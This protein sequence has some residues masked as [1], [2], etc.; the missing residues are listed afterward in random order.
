ME[1][2]AANTPADSSAEEPDITP[3]AAAAPGTNLTPGAA[4][5]IDQMRAAVARPPAW[6]EILNGPEDGRTIAIDADHNVIGR[7]GAPPKPD[8]PAT[9]IALADG[10][11]S[12]PHAELAWRDGQWWITDLESANGT[13]VDDHALAEGAPTPL[14]PGTRLQLGHTDLWLRLNPPP[15]LP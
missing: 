15:E 2:T 7:S 5:R 8:R 12:N 9:T 14:A 11:V 1:P 3:I 4:A 13:H 10:F 6:L